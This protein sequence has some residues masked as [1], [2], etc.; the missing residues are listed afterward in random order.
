[1]AEAGWVGGLCPL[2]SYGRAEGATGRLGMDGG[3]PVRSSGGGPSPRVGGLDDISSSDS[4]PSL[5]DKIWLGGGRGT[6]RA[7]IEVNQPRHLLIG[8]PDLHS[9]GGGGT[10]RSEGTGGGAALLWIG[11]AETERS[12]SISTVSIEQQVSW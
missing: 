7:V 3:E 5:G 6:G 2:K 4:E 11:S 9:A 8:R 12:V 10:G 1:M